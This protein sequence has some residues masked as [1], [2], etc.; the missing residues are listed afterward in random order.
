MRVLRNT[1]PE[2]DRTFNLCQ[3]V[4]QIGGARDMS[5]RRGSDDRPW[6]VDGQ[7][8]R[9]FLYSTREWGRAQRGLDLALRAAADLQA[10][11]DVDAGFFVYQRRARGIDQGT[12]TTDVYAPWGPFAEGM[13]N[14]RRVVLESLHMVGE[15]ES[16]MERWIPWTAIREPWQSAWGPYELEELGIWPLMSREHRTGLLVVG[17]T[18]KASSRI[19]RDTR[20]GIVDACAAHVAQALD[21]LLATRDAEE[22]GRRDGL[23]GLLNR[24]GLLDYWPV[25]QRAA[26]AAAKP[27]IIGLLDMDQ[28]KQINDRKGHPAGDSAL[29]RV[30]QVLR[31]HLRSGDLLAR[32]GG[33]EFAVV[34]QAEDDDA[35][36]VMRRLQTAVADETPY[37]VSV[38]GAVWTRDG[39]TWDA[40]YRVADEG[41]YLDKRRA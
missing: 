24:R 35:L 11:A 38:G 30:A 39:N 18:A 14:V 29:R 25:V 9:D 40:C 21:L 6:V 27:V 16:W 5:R 7:I 23:T 37:T 33:D 4:K 28:L 17:R 8:L 13:D 41:L 26:E 31:Y 22:A 2:D 15:I 34:M 36:G 3:N 12:P 1:V 10:W 19:A 20:T 32:W